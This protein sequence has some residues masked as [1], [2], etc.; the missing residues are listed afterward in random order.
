VLIN[1]S[2]ENFR[3][4]GGEQTLNLIASSK[5]Q[6][7]QDHCVPIG[8]TGRSVLRAGV[9]YG[10]NAAGKSNLIRAVLFAQ[11]L[12]Q[13]TIPFKQLALNQ[14]RFCKGKKPSSFE[15]RF[16]VDEQIFV[17]GFAITSDAV[18]EEWLEATTKI[19]RTIKVFTRNGQNISISKLKAF[20]DES[21][22]SGRAM[23][24]LKILPPRPDQ[25]LLN[26]IVD[27]PQSSR[28]EL[29]NRAAWWFSEC[30]TVVQA[31]TSFAHLLEYIDKDDDFRRFAGAFLNNVGTGVN[32]LHLEQAEIGA[33][34]MPKELLQGL[35]A[36]P[37]QE[38]TIL[39]DSASVSIQL[40]PKDPTK[41]IRRNLAARHR[42][43]NSTFSIPF[44]DESDGTQRCLHLLPALYHLTKSRKVF[45]IDE[46]N[47]SLHPLLCHAFLKFFVESSCAGAYQ[48]QLV[49]TTHETHLLDQELLRRDEI[50]F[51]EKDDEQQTQLYSLADMKI[52]ND[53]RI[54]KGYLQ[55]RFGGIPFIGDT[56]KL[57]DMLQSPTTGKTHAKKTTS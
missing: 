56:Q 22:T 28:G 32:D 3:S 54:E 37:G 6:D 38:T 44:Q 49:L 52:R 30:L 12:I 29:L 8:A 50:W 15:F 39:L 35:Q 18:V 26:K 20:G 31:R 9:V 1:F 2:V 14:F 48:Q 53:M 11:S 21:V 10:A 5:L 42:V 41:V 45:V 24:A 13:G 57:M 7:H 55:G 23:E 17:Y 43:H 51:V 19:G 36:P 34:K 25:L 4:F 47:Q 40:D 27:L 33:E 46:L 16:L